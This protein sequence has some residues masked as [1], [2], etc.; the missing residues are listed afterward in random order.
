MQLY[1]MVIIYKS[2][3]VGYKLL[4][5]YLFDDI[6]QLHDGHADESIFSG[7]AVV[8]DAD[9]QLESVERF[10]VSDGAAKKKKNS[11]LHTK[12]CR[13]RFATTIYN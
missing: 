5:Q 2:F 13:T 4:I 9:V 7:E 10:L 12:L 8:F 6:S 3:G 11:N 1:L